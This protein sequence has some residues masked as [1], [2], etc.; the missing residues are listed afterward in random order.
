MLHA[1]VLL[2]LG[3]ELGRW[4]WGILGNRPGKDTGLA[5]CIREDVKK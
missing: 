4:R 1:S 3:K 2:V 5:R